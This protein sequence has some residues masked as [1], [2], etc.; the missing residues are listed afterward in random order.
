MRIRVSHHTRYQYGE[1]ANYTIQPIRLIPRDF[2]GQRVVHWRVFSEH[3]SRL[4]EIIDGHGNIVATHTVNAPHQA[5][6]IIV[7]GLVETV[8]TA[9]FM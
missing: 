5:S 2:D 3:H 1:A 6:E 8:D 4:P 7:E 9:S